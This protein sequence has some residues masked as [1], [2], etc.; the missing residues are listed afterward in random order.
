MSQHRLLPLAIGGR[1]TGRLLPAFVEA[2]PESSTICCWN[3][4]SVGFFVEQ[5]FVNDAANVRVIFV[6]RTPVVIDL[7][8]WI[9]LI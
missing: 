6:K 5:A 7:H 1:V 4:S 3:P 8:A 9:S 2:T